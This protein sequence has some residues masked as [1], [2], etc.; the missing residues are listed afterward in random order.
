MVNEKKKQMM[1]NII[2]GVIVLA[3][4]ITIVLGNMYYKHKVHSETASAAPVSVQVQ[5]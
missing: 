5:M 1:F 4:I 2:A 3:A